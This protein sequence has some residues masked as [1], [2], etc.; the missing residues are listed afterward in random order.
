MNQTCSDKSLNFVSSFQRES[1]ETCLISI[2]NFIEN[3]SLKAEKYL[4]CQN[5]A[6]SFKSISL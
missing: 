2:L 5:Y 4:K 1:F 6:L 3:I